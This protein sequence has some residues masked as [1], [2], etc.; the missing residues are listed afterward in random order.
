M[1][2]V[3]LQLVL[4]NANICRCQGTSPIAFFVHFSSH[5]AQLTIIE[6]AAQDVLKQLN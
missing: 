6:G 5:L 3:H 4:A 2:A 1:E